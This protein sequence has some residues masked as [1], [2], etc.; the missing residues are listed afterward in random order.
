[1][2]AMTLGEIAAAVS[3]RLELGD[4]EATADTV[5]TGNSQTDSRE[6]QHGEIFFARRGEETDGHRFVGSAIDSGAALIVGERVVD[7]RVPTIVVPETTEA[8]GALAAEVVRRVDALGTLRIIGIT[9]S[10]GKTTTK[11]LVREMC[12]RLGETV[13]SEKSFNN[14]VGGPLT[15]LRITETT[16]FLV[17][18]MGAS[19]E[20]EIRRLTAMAPPHIGVVLMVGLAHAGEFGGIE[21]TVRTKSEMVQDLPAS[22]TAVLNADD[23]RVRAMS[24]KTGAQTVFFGSAPEAKVRA[25]GLESTAA[26][27]EFTLT[28]GEQSRRVRFPVLGEHHVTNALAAAA[29]AHTLGL[30]LDDIVDVLERTTRPAKWRMEVLRCRDGI[31]VINDAYNASPDSMRAALKTLAQ[32][33][34]PEGRTVAVLG[35]MSELGEFSGQEHD[36][37]GT[38]AVRLRLSEVVVVGEAVRRMYTTA[39]NEGAWSESEA[40]YFTAADAALEHLLATLQPHDTVL[41]KSSNS[42]GLRFLGDDL[43]RAL[44]QE[45]VEA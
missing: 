43:A 36:R 9:G 39:V 34:K 35:E 23:P 24:E 6:V 15:M 12:Q 13:A 22:A 44:Q 14:E 28:I 21:T 2:I 3:G 8:L 1:M 37:V 29:V 16:E 32:V 5:I 27:T 4:S 33:G 38:L 31:T 17:A 40:S 25:E 18:E 7:P 30:A 20:G 45:E 42:A 26:G 41:V 10:N 19:G 11:N